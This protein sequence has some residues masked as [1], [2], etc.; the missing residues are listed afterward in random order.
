MRNSTSPQR[1]WLMS[2][3]PT[4][5]KSRV[6][7]FTPNRVRRSSA[8]SPTQNS[9]IPHFAKPVL[10]SNRSRS[11][12]GLLDGPSEETFSEKDN[13]KYLNDFN[14]E[15]K[16]ELVVANEDDEENF[17]KKE[18]ENLVNNESENENNSRCNNQFVQNSESNITNQSQDVDDKNV[19]QKVPGELDRDGLS[20]SRSYEDHLDSDSSFDPN[21]SMLS[22]P[23]S[24]DGK[25]K[26]NFMDKCVSKVRHLIR[27]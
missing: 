18:E 16:E 9:R 22:L 7:Q 11:L 1:T 26:R 13:P 14:N 27:K 23:N 3:P 24:G 20:K 2:R 10:C 25:R 19:E 21:G 5:P 4:S 12:D 17:C 15:S 8:Q 6:R